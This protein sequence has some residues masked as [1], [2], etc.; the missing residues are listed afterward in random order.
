MKRITFNQ[1][2]L[3]AIKF[4]TFYFWSSA[5]IWPQT[6]YSSEKLGKWLLGWKQVIFYLSFRSLGTIDACIAL[7]NV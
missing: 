4:G 1:L 2:Y 3:T 6:P 7:F 5:R